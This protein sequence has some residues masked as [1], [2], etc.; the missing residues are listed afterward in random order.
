MSDL[1]NIDGQKYRGGLSVYAC[2]SDTTNETLL[3]MAKSSGI[4]TQERYDELLNVQKSTKAVLDTEELGVILETYFGFNG[5]EYETHEIVGAQKTRFGKVLAGELRYTGE[6][7]TDKAWCNT[8]LASREAC[9]KNRYGSVVTMEERGG[10]GEL[11]LD[12]IS[13][14][15]SNDW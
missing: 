14:G 10:V 7:R 3:R 11:S 15:S 5:G 13:R 8:G 12:D 9:E 1:K 4:I 6:E 2:Q